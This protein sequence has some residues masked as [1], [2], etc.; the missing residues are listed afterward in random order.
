MT[1]EFDPRRLDGFVREKVEK[2]LDG[3]SSM[4]VSAF[5]WS[6]TPQGF[7]FWMNQCTNGLTDEGRAL[8]TDWL[9]ITA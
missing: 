5:V 4:I 2:V 3:D 1:Q 6:A 7:D 9:E 8:L